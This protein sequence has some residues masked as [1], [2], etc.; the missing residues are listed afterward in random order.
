MFRFF[1]TFL[2]P[3]SWICTTTAATPNPTEIARSFGWNRIDEIRLEG[4]TEAAAAFH[5]AQEW[6]A[7]LVFRS[8]EERL[9]LSRWDE[10]AGLAWQQDLEFPVFISLS[11]S[12][13]GELVAACAWEEES[14]LGFVFDRS[15][16]QRFREPLNPLS[17]LT[18]FPDGKSWSVTWA[19][20]DWP[21][22]VA[23]E[24]PM[25]S[26]L[27]E[28]A[29]GKWNRKSITSGEVIWW[30]QPRHHPREVPHPALCYPAF[31]LTDPSGA[32]LFSDQ[33][34]G[35]FVTFFADVVCG[36]DRLVLVK[37][38]EDAVGNQAREMIAL[39]SAGQELWRVR[40]H[41][42]SSQVSGFIHNQDFILLFAGK[43]IEYRH[44]SGGN[45]IASDTLNG[46]QRERLFP[47]QG[48]LHKDEGFILLGR[49]IS[50]QVHLN[51]GEGIVHCE[52]L[53]MGGALSFDGKLGVLYSTSSDSAARVCTV[54][55]KAE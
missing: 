11:S 29:G 44:A 21:Q 43:D 53:E 1:I 6:G 5:S 7:Y 45:L 17:Q 50:V 12:V 9:Q 28:C 20:F 37:E 16:A 8:P 52:P 3:L 47:I 39:S 15:G 34:N 33:E 42:Q 46:L 51:P 10:A 4:P 14:V 55:K 38:G 31:V 24:A 49:Q 36:D 22:A 26:M 48:F 2:L 25:I 32:L 13:D 54:F 35:G 18:V 23:S 30:Y 40:A 41:R 19:M 27:P